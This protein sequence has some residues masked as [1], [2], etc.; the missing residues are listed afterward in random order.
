MKNS[1]KTQLLI[2][3]VVGILLFSFLPTA[4]GW[5]SRKTNVTIRPIED[6]LDNNPYGAG[7]YYMTGFVGSDRNDHY[8]WTWVVAI[9]EPY[10]GET[11]EYS[12]H[13]K[14]K[15]MKDGSIEITVNLWVKNMVIEFYD[16]EMD[17]NNNPIWDL[18]YLG[19]IVLAGRI[20]YYFQLKF[21]LDAT[22]EGSEYA[23][24]EPGTREAGCELPTCE[25]IY[26]IP[27]EM[28]IHLQSLM[29]I[30]SGEGDTY[31][32]GWYWWMYDPDDPTTLPVPDGGTKNIFMF[33]YAK[34]G[35]DDHIVWPYGSSGFKF[36]TA[37]LF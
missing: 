4:Q 24:F 7:M 1:R 12:G 10:I 31:V 3:A 9:T 29:F 21:T 6:W 23:G 35:S 26:Y 2:V 20:N 30:A 5:C 36:A 8:Y 15:V 18:G 14:E 32:P 13:V 11:F 33:H 34:F 17:E 19:Q 28:G 37:C 27:D 16:A 25:M 22:Y